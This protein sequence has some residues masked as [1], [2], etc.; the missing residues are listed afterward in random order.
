MFLDGFVMF[1]FAKAQAACKRGLVA[2]L[3]AI[4][5]G[6]WMGQ[7]PPLRQSTAQK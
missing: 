4:R 2:G 1:I 3:A 7:N 6:G 5:V